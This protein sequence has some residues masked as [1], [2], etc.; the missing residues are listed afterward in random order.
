MREKFSGRECETITQ[1][2]APFHVTPSR[3]REV[4]KERSPRG[5]VYGVIM[6]IDRRP[7]G[8]NGRFP[9]SLHV[10]KITG[11][12][13]TSPKRPNSKEIPG[14][15]VD[16]LRPKL[17]STTSSMASYRKQRSR[18]RLIGRGTRC[19]STGRRPPPR[20][21]RCGRPIRYRSSCLWIRGAITQALSTLSARSMADP[22]HAAAVGANLSLKLW[23]EAAETWIG[24]ASRWW[25]LAAPTE[26]KLRGPAADR[27]FEAPEMGAAPVFPGPQAE[28]SRYRCAASRGSR[29]RGSR[30]D[31][32]APPHVP[33]PTVDRRDESDLVSADE[34][35][36]SSQGIGDGWRQRG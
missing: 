4:Y 8:Q 11:A 6:T 9:M 22:V 34:P 1:P 30:S 23:Q 27:R 31:R 24:A 36:G 25:G 19:L 17:A 16:R 2:P 35:G 33:R 5:A 26:D 14:L 28:L 7:E 18:S 13:T 21:T 3:R 20:S 29:P 12:S 32:T 10:S 15:P